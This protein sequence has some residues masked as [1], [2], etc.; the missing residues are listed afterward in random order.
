[1][2][3]SLPSWSDTATKRAII[4]FVSAVTNEHDPAYVPPADRVATFDNDGTLWCEKPTYIQLDYFLRRLA[5]QAE[6]DP[7]LR[8]REPWRAAWA[9]DHA[10]FG[11]GVT[12]HYQGDDSDLRILLKGILS[13]AQEQTAVGV[14]AAA[15]VFVDSVRHPTLGLLYRDCTYQP[16]LELL[17]YLEANHFTNVIVSGGGRDFMR[18]VATELYGV[19]RERVIGS[20]VAYRFEDDDDGGQ[21]YQRPELDMMTDGAAKPV[22]IWDSIGRRPIIAVGNSDGDIP[23]L[24]FAGARSPAALRLLVV[25]DDPERE[26]DYTAGAEKAIRAAEDAGWRTVSMRDDWRRIFTAAAPPTA[27]N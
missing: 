23:M 13:L 9:K 3:D 20:T 16:M 12:K 22:A 10:W 11:E 21:I 17:H 6:E 15:K 5:A 7:S 14:E 8:S 18:G 2:Q 1:M 26:F 25:H 19:P 24:K 27:T 4:D